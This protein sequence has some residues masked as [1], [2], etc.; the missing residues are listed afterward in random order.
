MFISFFSVFLPAIYSPSCALLSNLL[1]WMQRSRC[2]YFEQFSLHPSYSPAS[3]LLIDIWRWS[4]HFAIIQLPPRNALF[5]SS[6]LS[7]SFANG[8]LL[9]QASTSVKTVL[10]SVSV[11]IAPWSVF[12]S[13]FLMVP[14]IRSITPEWLGDLLG[15]WYHEIDRS[16]CS[17]W[18]VS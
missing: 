11:S 5:S 7:D 9:M 12:M 1:T 10:N 6:A 13:G 18:W 8:L 17:F 14:T 4:I 3:W 15:A 16:S 2:L